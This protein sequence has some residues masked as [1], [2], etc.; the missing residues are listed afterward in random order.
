MRIDISKIILYR[1]THVNNLDDILLKGML[2]SPNHDKAN[3][4]Y[5]QIGDNSLIQSRSLRSIPLPPFGSFGDYVSFY[6]CYRSPMLYEIQRGFQVG[7]K[8]PG[9]I[10]YFVSS[11]K[12]I[13]DEGCK[14][15]FSDGHAAAY[16]SQFFAKYSELKN[17]DWNIINSKYWFDNDEDPDR[18]RRKQAEFLVYSHVPLDA[19]IGIGVYNEKVKNDV[20]A[21]L[22][23]C[24]IKNLI[25]KVK[26]DYYY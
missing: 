2:C 21:L 16:S 12:K 4:H 20:E 15:V 24:N 8:E 9:E 22:Q 18:K 25:V 17:I 26:E 6:F 19:V 11:I 3:P 5:T 1:I 14:Y 10:I 7:K 13:K 23:S